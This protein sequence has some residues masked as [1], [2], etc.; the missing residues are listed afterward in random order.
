MPKPLLANAVTQCASSTTCFNLS[1]SRWFHLLAAL[2]IIINQ[3]LTLAGSS[4]LG[5]M[6]LVIS[7]GTHPAMGRTSTI[8]WYH[9]KAHWLRNVLGRRLL[10]R[11]MFSISWMWVMERSKNNRSVE[12]K[13]SGCSF[14]VILKVLWG[15]WRL[16][17]RE[18][19]FGISILG[20]DPL[21]L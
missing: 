16:T 4:G 3:T 7:A 2:L 19:C 6:V 12:E 10:E 18:T 8:I 11:G 9:S 20:S 1:N 21:L 5:H 15:Y 17:W 14:W 13:Q